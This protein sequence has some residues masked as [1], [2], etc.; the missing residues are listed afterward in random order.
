MNAHDR[1][2]LYLEQRRELGE[3]E[4]VLDEL[5]IEAVLKMIGAPQKGAA[6]RSAPAD[7]PA[8]RAPLEQ[9]QAS[10]PATAESAPPAATPAG[11]AHTLAPSDPPARFDNTVSTDW[12]ATL[13]GLKPGAQPKGVETTRDSNSA[14]V[15]NASSAMHTTAN[16]S[17]AQS[18]NADAP[19]AAHAETANHGV[20]KGESVFVLPVWLANL[21]LPAGLSA[22]PAGDAPTTAIANTANSLDELA[23]IISA[24]RACS[25]GASATHP[26]PGEGN[27]SADLVCVGEAP[28]Q[29]EDETGRPFVG[30]AGQ[31]LTK[32][33]AAIQ[34]QREDVFICNVLK[35]RPPGNRNPAPEEI[36]ACTPYLTRQLELVRPKVILALGTF[37]AQTLL[38]TTTPLG[39][40]RGQVHRYQGVPLIVTYHPAALL[41]NESWKRPTWDDVKLARRI[42]DAARLNDSVSPAT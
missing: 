6:L 9:A 16:G 8:V 19:A 34:L 30:A 36:R 37:A 27:T 17:S 4:F 40:L 25:L 13:S 23:T 22:N 33:L 20:N 15:A 3:S 24:C 5:P 32:I 38:N 10:M 39:K 26:V 7:T 2:R 35:H 41:R 31:L 1:L 14:P 42:L 18:S 29:T 21:G 28:G 11:S 12:R